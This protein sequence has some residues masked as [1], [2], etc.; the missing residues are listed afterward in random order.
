MG[1]ASLNPK[2][3]AIAKLLHGYRSKHY[4][5]KADAELSAARAKEL[6]QILI[7]YFDAYNQPQHRD[8]CK[9]LRIGRHKKLFRVAHT[10]AVNTYKTTRPQSAD[11]MVKL[12]DMIE[13]S[14]LKQQNKASKG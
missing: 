3:I 5:T 12:I 4:D 11:A 10:Y 13:S 1:A 14:I 2:H 9:R 8:F 7:A 6:R